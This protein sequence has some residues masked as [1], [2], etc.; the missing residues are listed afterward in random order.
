MANMYGQNSSQS[1]ATSSNDATRRVDQ[2]PPMFFNK[3]V[4]KMMRGGGGAKT[5][6]TSDPFSVRS[7]NPYAQGGGLTKPPIGIQKL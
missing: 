5:Q 7:G 1:T 3:K 6:K 2:A 4:V